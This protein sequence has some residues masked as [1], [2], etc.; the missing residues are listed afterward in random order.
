MSDY[1]EYRDE[2]YDFGE[3]GPQTNLID[4]R[5]RS[6]IKSHKINE[7]KRIEEK[8]KRK[9]E[10]EKLECKLH[11]AEVDKLKMEISKMASNQVNANVIHL[12]CWRLPTNS[13]TN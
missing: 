1:I 5:L 10:L 9:A 6:S 8:E 3:N 7:I 4:E 13:P 2:D 12:A 11:D